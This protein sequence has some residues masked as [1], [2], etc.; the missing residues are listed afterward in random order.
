MCLIGVVYSRKADLDILFRVIYLLSWQIKLYKKIKLLYLSLEFS[1]ILMQIEQRHFKESLAC[2][3]NCEFKT[4]SLSPSNIESK[5]FELSS[6]GIFSILG[7]CLTNLYY[8]FLFIIDILL[9]ISTL[10]D[11]TRIRCRWKKW[12]L[13][14]LLSVLMYV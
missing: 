3:L 6:N 9:Y 7:S 14:H 13:S 12:S 10:D 2:L 11:S 5:Y 8:Y 1:L 4:C